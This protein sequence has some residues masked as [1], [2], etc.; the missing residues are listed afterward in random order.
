MCECRLMSTAP[1]SSTARFSAKCPARPGT[2]DAA[3]HRRPRAG[4]VPREGLGHLTGLVNRVPSSRVAPGRSERE[5]RVERASRR[6]K[7][8]LAIASPVIAINP[9][10][11]AMA[12]MRAGGR[13]A[14]NTSPAALLGRTTRVLASHSQDARRGDPWPGIAFVEVTDIP[15]SSIAIAWRPHHQPRAVRAIAAIAAELSTA[16][17]TGPPTPNAT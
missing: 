9:R 4:V 12:R 1:L 17:P 5:A 3:R 14:R 2:D 15:P 16:T 11:R 6:V 13:D 8:D 7:Q 10:Q